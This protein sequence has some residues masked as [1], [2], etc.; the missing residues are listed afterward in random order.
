MESTRHTAP[1]QV[2]TAFSEIFRAHLRSR[3]FLVWAG[4]MAL[5]GAIL[6]FQPLFDL[7]GFEWCF[8]IGICAAPA[9]IDTARGLVH[10]VRE[11]E[12]HALA[13]PTTPTRLIFAL[14]GVSIAQAWLLLVVPTL[15]IA[16]NALRVP[17]CDPWTGVR[18]L[19]VM[20]LPGAATSAVLGMTAAL[21]MPRRWMSSLAAQLFLVGSILWGVYRFYAA[22]AI[23]G[24]D[25]FVGF[26]PG[27]LYDEEL[28]IPR[29]LLWYRLYATMWV[30]AAVAF[31]IAA[32]DARHVRL[33][34]HALAERRRSIGVGLLALGAAIFL[35]FQ[36]GRLGW[37]P[38]AGAVADAL[39]G[40][41]RTRHFDI[42][43]DASGAIADEIELVA[44]DHEFRYAQLTEELGV[45]PAGRITSFVFE[46][47][48][49]KKRWMGAGDTYIAKPWRREIYVQAAGFPH[50]VI[51][52][53]LA[54]VFAGAFGD[55]IFKVAAR[56]A[57]WGPL[58]VPQFNVGLI[59][60]LAVAADWRGGGRL[61]P[62][63][64]TR[65][66]LELELAP[67]PEQLFGYGFLNSSAGRSYTTAG[68]FCRWLID[69]YG[70]AQM[71]RVYRSGG[72]FAGVYGKGLGALGVE[73][74]SFLLKVP[75]ADED[76]E[77][78][79]EI[80]RRPGIFHAPCARSVASAR[81]RAGERA[82][83]G[84]TRG[85]VA[86]WHEV[87]RDD[88]DDPAN[89][90]DLAGAEERDQQPALALAT[91]ERVLSHKK[92]SDSLRARTLGE[93][94][95]LR[96]R[97]G[98]RAGAQADL[99]AA[100]ALPLDE[101]AERLVR[102]QLYALT[103]PAA[104]PH[105]EAYFL[106]ATRAREGRSVGATAKRALENDQAMDLLHAHELSAALPEVGF[107]PYLVGRVL[108]AK[109]RFTEAVPYLA[110]AIALGLPHPTFAREA[111]RNLVLAAYRAG[112]LATARAAAQRLAAPDQPTGTQLLGQDWL[113]R[114][115]FDETGALPG[116]PPPTPSLD[117]PAPPAPP[118]DAGIDDA[119][120]DAT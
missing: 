25:A 23:F 11:S 30:V 61:T 31:A 77:L 96:W 116:Q 118:V 98:D 34:W 52:H 44:R 55:R 100:L 59:E 65:A 74:R 71:R 39:G 47:E 62:H 120:P 1:R 3:R 18:W 14:L 20:T 80:F 72:D 45:E 113:D 10:R 60:G 91:L 38:S 111:D 36:D 12:L 28:S 24:H 83:R 15:L 93:R 73:W 92:T 105:L 79:R 29:A 112:D 21:L 46:S 27:T 99:E 68:S 48:A 41:Y 88:A 78:A 109:G 82:A 86:A 8:A 33:R 66:L 114:L 56:V 63:Q 106:G 70:I 107:G 40:R 119:G 81:A 87:C 26:F 75:L 51:K 90:V 2:I 35:F 117:P 5:A 43:Y 94:A 19:L 67:R 69:R 76:R 85:A 16:L 17:L 102:A 57:W 115:T 101:N 108:T 50:P 95:R 103:D 22:P 37:Y 104:A 13:R 42:I 53:E 4:L 64:W 9:A 6:C 49:Q 84:D 97:Q 89:L 54:H 58:P 7:F 110:R 32:V